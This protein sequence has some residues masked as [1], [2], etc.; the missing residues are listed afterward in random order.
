MHLWTHIA[1]AVWLGLAADV[2]TRPAT[3][4]DYRPDLLVQLQVANLDRA[5]AFYRDVL[6]FEIAERRDDLKFAHVNTNVPGLQIGL[7]ESPTLSPSTPR[8]AVDASTRR[9]I[10]NIGVRDVE[11]ARRTLE[12]RGVT[13]AKPTHIIPGKVALAEFTDPDGNVLR[14][15]GP[16]PK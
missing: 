15:A 1:L 13:F 10:L 12:S 4:I 5:V 6:R 9:I 8:R 7:N 11:A 2:R 14:F 16:P 3:D